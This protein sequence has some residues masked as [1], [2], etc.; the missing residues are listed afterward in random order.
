MYRI[1]RV[2]TAGALLGATGTVFYWYGYPRLFGRFNLPEV[3]FDGRVPSRAEQF[4]RL[5]AGTREDPYDV[6]IVGGGATGSGC[7]VDAASRYG[8]FWRALAEA[9]T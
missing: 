5:V 4:D 2:L 1:R 9:C 7:A 6:L 3:A 8:L